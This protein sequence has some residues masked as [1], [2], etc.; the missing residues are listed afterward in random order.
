MV[1][2]LNSKG[3]PVDEAKGMLGYDTVLFVGSLDEDV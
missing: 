3:L 2:G 1:R